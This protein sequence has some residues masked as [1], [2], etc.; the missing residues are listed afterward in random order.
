MF[1]RYNQLSRKQITVLKTDQSVNGGKRVGEDCYLASYFILRVP[2]LDTLINTGQII[3]CAF[4]RVK[5]YVHMP[6]YISG[7]GV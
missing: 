7:P 1:T 2:K 5:Q 3:R 6:G 4:F